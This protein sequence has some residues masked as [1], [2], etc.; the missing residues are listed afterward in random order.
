MLKEI[1]DFICTSNGVTEIDIITKF[2]SITKVKLSSILNNLLRTKQIE[3]QNNGHD[4]IYKKV[5]SS[6][7]EERII[8]QLITQNK[9]LWLKDIKMRTNIPQNLISKLLKQMENKKMIKSLKS[10]KN[11]RKVYVLYDDKPSEELTGGVWFNDGNI[12]TELVE[13]IIKIIYT[14]LCR[15]DNKNIENYLSIEKVIRFLEENKIMTVNLN[16]EDVETLMNVMVYEEY[17]QEII[18]DDVAVYRPLK[19]Q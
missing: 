16:Y 14:H 19:Q 11:N 13:E 15:I 17:V 6:I 5:S 8:Y 4:L 12:D 3:I 18:I 2:K 9:G 1:Q 10:V 7:E